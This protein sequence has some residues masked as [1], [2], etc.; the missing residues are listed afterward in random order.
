MSRKPQNE[1]GAMRIAVSTESQEAVKVALVGA[2]TG[3]GLGEL[4]REIDRARRMRKRIELDL[5]EVTLL[6][7]H[8]VSFLADQSRDDVRLINCPVYIEPWIARELGHAAAG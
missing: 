1:I 7:R 6:D 8:S 2:M 5:G 3:V 4:R